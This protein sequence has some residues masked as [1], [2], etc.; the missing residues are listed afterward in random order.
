[1]LGVVKIGSSLFN[2]PTRK[3]LDALRKFISSFNGNLAFVTGAG[4]KYKE[5]LENYRGFGFPEGFLDQLGIELTHVNA[6]A[7]A[8]AIGGTYC[9]TFRDVDA[10][11]L[12]KPVTG[13][14]VPG[15]S[16][17]AVAAE[18]ADFLGADVLIFVKDVG[19]IYTQDPKEEPGAR[20]LQ[21]L[22]FDEL[23]EFARSDTRAGSYGVLDS[24]AIHIM[25]RSK[26]KTYVTGVGLDLSDATVIAN[27]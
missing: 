11:R 17:D 2:D 14:Q 20:K 21:K 13:G 1:M 6:M 18:L 26:I 3:E 24:Q 8:R 16:T 25:A 5:A 9:R 10:G 22:S 4:T 19:G 15:Q 12:R 23:R 27:D 7:L